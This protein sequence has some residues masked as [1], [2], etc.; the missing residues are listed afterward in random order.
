MTP[1]MHVWTY[2]VGNYTPS[3]IH[4]ASTD[5]EEIRAL[6]AMTY[7]VPADTVTVRLTR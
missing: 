5:P 4:S 6:V 3:T 1:T 2:T 7:R